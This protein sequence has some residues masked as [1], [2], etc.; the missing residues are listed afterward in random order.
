MARVVPGQATLPTLRVLV[1]VEALISPSRHSYTARLCCESCTDHPPDHHTT[2]KDT[3]GGDY[4]GQ[5][6]SN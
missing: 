6:P 5:Q 2:R 4:L 1:T 3:M